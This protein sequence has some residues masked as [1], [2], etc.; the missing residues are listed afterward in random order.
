MKISD[1][2]KT[3][4]PTTELADTPII[5]NQIYDIRGKQVML[6]SDVA[7]YFQVETKYLNRQ[8]QRNKIRFPK[9]FCFKINS[10]EFKSLRCQNVT[11]NDEHLRSQ[12]DV[13]K[14]GGKRYLPYVY[15]EHGIIALAGVIKS[16]IAAEA[17]VKIVRQFVDMRNFINS[18][19]HLLESL[20][21]IQNRQLKFEDETNQ[22]FDIIFRK[23]EH[24]EIPRENI[25][26]KEEFFDA[27]DFII[28]L[29]NKAQTS[30][31]LIDPYCDEKALSFF[32]GKKK[33]I[34]L[35]L[36]K[37]SN[38][39]LSDTDVE[40]YS[41]Q[42]GSISVKDNDDIHDRFLIIDEDEC[43]SLGSSLNYLGNKTVVMTQ[44]ESKEIIKSIIKAIC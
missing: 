2:Q 44:I 35:R 18:N 28:K 29:I 16:K 15:T 25:F 27:Y 12:K 10:K 37:S 3:L 38:A 11:S 34:E 33:E 31:L 23:I 42:Y 1:K 43:Y 19:G 22:K 20:S 30:I 6:D 17:S 36:V 26:F 40:R 39:K 8:M 41:S 7:F 5:E 14:R 32:K 13:S 4:L 21:T 9:E 24:H